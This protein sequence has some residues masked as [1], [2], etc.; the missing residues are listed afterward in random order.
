MFPFYVIVYT[1]IVLASYVNPNYTK[2][3]KE[4]EKIRI[5]VDKRYMENIKKLGY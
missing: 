2:T 1:G 3:F 5:A 4:V